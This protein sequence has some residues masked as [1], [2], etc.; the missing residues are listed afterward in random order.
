MVASR[1][2]ISRLTRHPTLHR[3]SLTKPEQL[4]LLFMCGSSLY[5]HTLQAYKEIVQSGA[6]VRSTYGI[7]EVMDVRSDDM[8]VIRPTEWKLANNCV[9]TFYI[10]QTPLPHTP[11]VSQVTSFKVGQTVRSTYG[12]GKILEVRKNDMLVIRPTNW[13]LANNCVPTFFIK[14]TPPSHTPGVTLSQ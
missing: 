10:K 5:V 9:P 1:H 3:W 2:S 4:S 6:I 14:A 7:G 8:L 11:F 12:I 13:N